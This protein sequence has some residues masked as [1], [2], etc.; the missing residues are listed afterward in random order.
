MS[1]WVALILGTIAY[2][3]AWLGIAAFVMFVHGDCWA[4]TTD[5]EAAACAR[6]KGWVG[7]AVIAL[8]AVLYGMTVWALARRSRRGK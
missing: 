1:K 5:A 6:E 8:A 7:L 4:G 2:W 3:L